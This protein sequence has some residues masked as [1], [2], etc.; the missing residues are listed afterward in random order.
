MLGYGFS[1]CP[2]LDLQSL[3]AQLPVGFSVSIGE[4]ADFHF[5]TVYRFIWLSLTVPR[6]VSE[7]ARGRRSSQRKPELPGSRISVVAMIRKLKS[8]QYRLYSSKK[9]PRLADAEIW[10]HS[11]LVRARRNTSAQSSI[12]QA[13]VIAIILV[14]TCKDETEDG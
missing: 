6:I 9:I 10:E 5:V 3:G 2:G 8:G 11:P 7:K 13:G 4:A 14:G 1:E 12:F